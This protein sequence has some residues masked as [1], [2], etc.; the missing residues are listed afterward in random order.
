MAIATALQWI[1][2]TQIEKDIFCT[3]S[4][5]ALKSLKSFTS[6]SRQDIVNEICENLYRFKNMNIL[7]IFMWIQAHRGIKGNE[8]VD[9]LAKQTLKNEEVMNFSLSKYEAK[10]V[11]KAYT[12]KEWQHKWDTLKTERHLY[13][14]Q[15]EVGVVRITKRSITEENILTRFINLTNN[16]QTSNRIM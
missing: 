8:K 5:S 1:E 15:R 16:K 6:H 7:I 13:E 14:I 4:C 11:I 9:S 10:A 2:V 12:T 3:D